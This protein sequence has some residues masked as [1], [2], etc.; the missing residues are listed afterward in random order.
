[1]RQ[2]GDR[3]PYRHGNATTYYNSNMVTKPLCVAIYDELVY[4]LDV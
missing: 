3:C 1:M 4:V 2:Q